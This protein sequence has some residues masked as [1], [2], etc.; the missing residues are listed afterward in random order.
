MLG[1][2]NDITCT[3]N[4]IISQNGKTVSDLSKIDYEMLN[5]LYHPMMPPGTT[6]LQAREIVGK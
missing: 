1:L 3:R 6:R 2:L 5:L 4:S